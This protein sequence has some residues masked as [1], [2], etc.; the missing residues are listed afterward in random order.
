MHAENPAVCRTEAIRCGL[1]LTTE[2]HHKRLDTGLQPLKRTDTVSLYALRKRT[3]IIPNDQH[4]T[5][6]GPGL[7]TLPSPWHRLLAA[8]LDSRVAV[9]HF[10]PRACLNR[11]D[12][13]VSP[14]PPD[15][16]YSVA[17]TTQWD[18]SWGSE[19]QV[20]NRETGRVT[21]CIHQEKEHLRL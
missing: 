7:T 5:S 1:D 10:E 17:S 13:S 8:P 3:V 14:D 6:Y 19:N 11:I 12:P 9:R 16:R 18:S 4:L 20:H 2:T 21:Y 15:R